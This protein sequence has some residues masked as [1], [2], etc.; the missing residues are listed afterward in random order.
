MQF[1]I[2]VP[3]YNNAKW[4]QK[5]L[6]SIAGQTYSNFHLYYID[7]A[8]EDATGMLAQ[9]YINSS[10]LKGKTTYIRNTKR[11]G[12]LA[13]LYHTIHTLQPDQIVVCV[14][15]DDWLAHTEVLTRL[16]A[17]YS[18]ESVWLTYGDFDFD[19][20]GIL[21]GHCEAIPEEVRKTHRFRTHSFL[22]SH[23]KTFYA[24]LFQKI[25]KEDLMIDGQF[26]PMTGDVAFM[27]PMLEMAASRHFR[28]IPETLY[29]YNVANPLND[30]KHQEQEQ[31][32]YRWIIQVRE[33]YPPLEKLF[34]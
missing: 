16:A 31:Q 4:C 25:R 26:F 24:K 33:P 8:S 13:N 32:Q 19:P 9:Q 22:A 2:V 29:I 23:V 10:S 12:S 20:Q 21:E 5:N 18:D 1:A 17:V 3:S 7:D 34:S 30:F 28:Y 6:A 11:Q 27:I 14:D 15:G